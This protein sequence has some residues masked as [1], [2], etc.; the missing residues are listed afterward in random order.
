MVGFSLRNSTPWRGPLSSGTAT[1]GWTW[2]WW[3]ANRAPG[4]FVEWLG[5]AEE[6]YIAGTLNECV[7]LQR[8][9]ADL[10]VSLFSERAILR[11]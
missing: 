5:K 1:A 6:I 10:G 2:G 9:Y 3:E 4:L 11:L 7:E 8:V